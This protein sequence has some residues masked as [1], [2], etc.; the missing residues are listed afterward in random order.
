MAKAVGKPGGG[1]IIEQFVRGIRRRLTIREVA[2][3]VFA[4]FFHDQRVGEPPPAL[5]MATYNYA[6]ES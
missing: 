2:E 5:Y 6:L 4:R 3:A 1:P